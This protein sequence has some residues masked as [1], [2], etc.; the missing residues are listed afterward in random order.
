MNSVADRW[1]HT[2]PLCVAAD[3][4][5]LPGHFPGRPVV[6][7]VVVLERVLEAAEAW[8]GSPLAARRL[9]AVKF[10]APLLPGVR[11]ELRLA[12]AEPVL[13]FEVADGERVLAQGQFELGPASVPA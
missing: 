8:L 2:A 4:P 12:W 10:T 11:A 7:G 1:Q 9:P 3:H 6:P 13:R 5:A